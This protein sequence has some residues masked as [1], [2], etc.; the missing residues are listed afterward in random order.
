MLNTLDVVPRLMA[1]QEGRAIRIA[2]HQR[3]AISADALVL[4]PMAMAGEDTTI[5]IVACGRIGRPAEIRCIPDPRY[6]DDQYR[7][8]EWL[9]ERIEAYFSACQQQGRYPQ[10]WVPSS[11]AVGLL[12]TLADRLR[13]NR[14]NPQVKRFGELLSYCTERYPV[15]GQ[16]TLLTA[17]G[18][19]GMHFAT[20]QQEAEDDHLGTWLV[21]VRP[22]ASGNVLAAVAV[23]EEIPM[24]VKTDPK[25]DRDQLEPLVSAYNQARKRKT[26]KPQLD[27]RSKQIEDVLRPVVATIYQATQ[28]AIAFLI[29]A[30]LPRMLHLDGLETREKE[31]FGSF[32]TSRDAGYHLPLRDAPKL[33]AFKLAARED[34]ADTAESAMLH[35]DM[36][37]LE[38]ARLAGRV[39]SGSVVDPVR[40][41]L[42]PRRF[43]NRFT[44]VSE[45]RVLHVRRRDELHLLSDPRMKVVVTDVRRSG[46]TT[47]VSV[48]L[49]KGE[50]AVGLPAANQSI[51]L[52]P[53][54]PEWDRLMRMRMQMRDRLANQPWTH[55]DGPLPAASPT[56]KPRPPDL[57][58]A[59]E[60]LR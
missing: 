14:E 4:C 47:R 12:D 15:E 48:M 59:I 45:Q 34:A 24:G 37:Q 60:G 5:H 46:R 22:P 10:I 20:G 33:A 50:R 7:L 30:R 26:P 9:A 27:R 40:S 11:A 53:G 13:F 43:E 49:L 8:F 56:G 31:E 54:P 39:L 41:R 17:T 58:A 21:W 36:V 57:L 29:A 55:S 32:M 19:L 51:A 25:F 2:S 38:R 44:V 23:A 16:Q 3:I 1:F 35:G 42:G 18:A 6:R 52:G 28:E